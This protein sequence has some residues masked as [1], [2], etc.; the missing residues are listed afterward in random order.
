[1][2]TV[3]GTDTADDCTDCVA[4]KFVN[5]TGSDEHFDC[6]DCVAD[7]YIDVAGSD[8]ASDCID[9]MNG[10]YQD[11]TGAVQ[12]K[13]VDECLF[14]RI[15]L[16]DGSYSLT[17]IAPRENPCGQLG[18]TDAVC[19]DAPAPQTGNNCTCSDTRVWRSVYAG[20]DPGVGE[21]ICNSESLLVG[22]IEISIGGAVAEEDFAVAMVAAVTEA[23]DIDEGFEESQRTARQ[24]SPVTIAADADEV[25]VLVN[26]YEMVVS[27]SIVLPGTAA[28]YDAGDPS[29]VPPTPPTA[30]YSSLVYGIT[31][32]ACGNLTATACLVSDIK[33]GTRRRMQLTSTV[34]VSYVV[35]A[36]QSIADNVAPEV[37]TQ[38]LVVA[39][40]NEP[41]GALTTLEVTDVTISEPSIDTNVEYTIVSSDTAVSTK[42]AE[43]MQNDAA[44]QRSLRTY[45]DGPLEIA[46]ECSNC[47]QVVELNNAT[48]MTVYVIIFVLLLSIAWAVGLLVYGRQTGAATLLTKTEAAV[49]AFANPMLDVA[50]GAVDVTTSV[51]TETVDATAVKGTKKA[52]KA[53]KKGAKKSA[54]KAAAIANPMYDGSDDED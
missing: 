31:T 49:G 4:G 28:D 10:K 33:L 1:M 5:V 41:G 46:I 30:Q 14:S 24:N 39:L 53:A 26:R 21:A 47:D 45:V 48:P 44:V 19:G 36:A 51:I 22:P 32:A 8:E 37:F 13:E 9:C 52:G 11:G 27:G 43:T 38:L 50:E 12:C 17:E 6:I 23:M 7:K 54:K 29:A 42:A 16:D 40:A 25:T 34:T 18:D 3:N 2:G 20:L 15:I 35:T